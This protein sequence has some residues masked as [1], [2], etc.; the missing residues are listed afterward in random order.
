MPK[1]NALVGL[2][3]LPATGLDFVLD[4]TV[5]IS[6]SIK[7]FIALAPADA[8]APATNTVAIR[9][10]CGIPCSAIIIPVRADS[11]NNKMNPGALFILT[12]IFLIIFGEYRRDVNNKLNKK[13][14]KTE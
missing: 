5:S 4:I 8:K 2:T 6:L 11:N 9:Y 10:S 7:L 12:G 13:T 3:L 14:Q 1:T